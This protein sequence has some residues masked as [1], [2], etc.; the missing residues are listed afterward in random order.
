MFAFVDCNMM[1]DDLAKW[2]YKSHS[3]G[4]GDFR[5][6]GLKFEEPSGIQTNDFSKLHFV[7]GAKAVSLFGKDGADVRPIAEVLDSLL[8]R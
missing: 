1:V 7:R 2:M 8:T 6:S 3:S 5:I 4:V